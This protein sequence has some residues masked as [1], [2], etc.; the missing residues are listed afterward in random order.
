MAA[1]PVGDLGADVSRCA[2]AV[3]G[4]GELPVAAYELLSETDRP[5]EMAMSWFL[6]KLSCHQY[7]FELEPIGEEVK[8]KARAPQSRR[9]HAGTWAPPRLPSPNC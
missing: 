2:A 3:E 7:K 6:A 4:P 9:C 8:Y 1:R 5:G